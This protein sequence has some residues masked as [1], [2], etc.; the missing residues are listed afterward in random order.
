[1]QFGRNESFRTINM[2][3]LPGK[4]VIALPRGSSLSNRSLM[5]LSS[6]SRTAGIRAG[7]GAIVFVLN[8]YR[9]RRLRSPHLNNME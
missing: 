2:D 3:Q 7:K 5:R 1:M 8:W 4:E 9:S 6:R